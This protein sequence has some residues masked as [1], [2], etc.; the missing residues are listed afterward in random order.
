M[1]AVCDE[2]CAGTTTSVNVCSMLWDL[3]GYHYLGKC[4]DCPEPP[5][6][7]ASAAVLVWSSLWAHAPQSATVRCHSPIQFIH[8]PTNAHT[9]TYACVMPKRTPSSAPT[10][11]HYVLRLIYRL[12]LCWYGVYPG[13]P[14]GT[15][16]MHARKTHLHFLKTFLRQTY[17]SV[18]IDFNINIE[19]FNVT[20][21]SG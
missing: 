15:N 8:I 4:V 21:Q 20:L 10:L 6:E 3:C 13:G 5:A 12:N 7:P 14:K 17:R 2:T 11:L 16:E 9:E 1:C 19:E 18:T